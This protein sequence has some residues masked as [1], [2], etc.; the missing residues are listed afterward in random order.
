MRSGTVALLVVALLA[1]GCG[2]GGATAERTATPSAAVVG[3]QRVAPRQLDLTIDSAALGTTAKV[4]LLTPR[5][6]SPSARRRWPVLYLMHGCCDSYLSW[7]R[8]TDVEKLPELPSGSG[9]SRGSRPTHARSGATRRRT[10]AS[11][12]AT[13]RPRSR[14]GC[15]GSRYS[16]HPETA[17]P[18]R[19][20]RR[21]PTSIP[22]SG[23]STR[24]AGHSCGGSARSA[25]R[26]KPTSTARAS[27]TGRTSSAS[28]SERS[29]SSSVRLVVERAPGADLSTGGCR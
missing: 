14:P 11:G 29:H 26:S 22:S 24:R 19:S 15:A 5:G 8:S 2:G 6:W 18:A 10:G 25:S 3:E 27:T 9:C 1:S 17:I 7:T 16:S 13:I 23:W 12:S 28:S 21:A 4:R 20:S